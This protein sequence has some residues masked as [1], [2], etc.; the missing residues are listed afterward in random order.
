M[1]LAHNQHLTLRN[2]ET[3][4]SGFRADVVNTLEQI[5]VSR[6]ERCG[7][8]GPLHPET[9]YRAST[10]A[11]GSQMAY[12]RESVI[13]KDDRG[14]AKAAFT[15]PSDLE[16]IAGIEEE[17]SKWLKDSLL[18]WIERGSPVDEPP[19]DPQGCV[20]RK[21]FVR[22]KSMRLRP[23]PQG[24]VTGGTLVR[25]D[26]FSKKGRFYLVPVYKHQLIERHPPNRAIAALKPEEK[27]DVLDSTF[28]FEFS[29]WRNS[30]FE[31]LFKDDEAIDGCY[32]YVNRN[33][34]RITFYPPDNTNGE[35]DANGKDIDHGFSTKI[36]VLSFRKISV[37]RLGRRFPVKKEKRTWRGAV[38]I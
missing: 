29:L 27:W 6:R 2:L 12:K 19:R 18:A 4:W 11:Y 17:R 35:K 5:T 33:T 13:T 23:Q 31:I 38:C 1:E 21:V 20:I 26:V 24:H 8:G 28:Q 16:K 7:A 3:P 10:D 22:Q 32:S 25:C 9:I 15:K 36:G 30:R 34:G 37:D 14:K